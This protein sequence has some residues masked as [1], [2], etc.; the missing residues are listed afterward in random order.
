M[1]QFDMPMNRE[2]IA[3]FDKLYEMFKEWMNTSD[4]DEHW[5]IREMQN[6]EGYS[7]WLEWMEENKPNELP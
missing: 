2:N 6:M 7:D 3:N 4:N 5:V 1:Q